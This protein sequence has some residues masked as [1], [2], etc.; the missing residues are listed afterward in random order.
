MWV[1]A[2]LLR[3]VF[4]LA[5]MVIAGGTAA[6]EQ[7]DCTGNADI[8]WDTQIAGCTAA[9]QSGRWQGKDLAWAFNNRAN[10]YDRTGQTDRA[11]QDY[12]QAIRL[13]PNYA[14][15]FNNRANAYREKTEFD[16][17]IQDYDQAI[18]IQ[19]NYAIALNNRGICYYAKM[20]YDRA[21]QEFDRAI[22]VDPNNAFAFNNRGNAF[23]RKGELDHALQDYDQAIRTNPKYG[24]AFFNRGR[25]NL[26]AA[27]RAPSALADFSQATTLDPKDAYSALWLDIASQRSHLPSKLSQ[28]ADRIDMK[29]WPAPVIQ[30]FLGRMA[31]AAVVTGAANPDAVKRKSQLCE[32]NFYGGEFLLRSGATAEATRMFRLAASDCPKAFTEW[33]GAVAELKS[34]GVTP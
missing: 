29:A 24:K 20:Q 12:N 1:K 27:G 16:R 26:F 17:A 34:M 11:I 32:A 6:A 3:S 4:A 28:A 30:M 10:A 9:I 23:S 19:P 21:I 5:A 33:E 18:E 8:A 25:A 2:R 15:A 14:A 31:P 13:D 7:L 22:R